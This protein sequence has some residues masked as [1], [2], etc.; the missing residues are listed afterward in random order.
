MIML[1]FGI[2]CLWSAPAFSWKRL[3]HALLSDSSVNKN[4]IWEKPCVKNSLQ[5]ATCISTFC[6]N[7]T[8]D[9]NSRLLSS[10]FTRE[11]HSYL[12][13]QGS[14]KS[15][16][17]ILGSIVVLGVRRGYWFFPLHSSSLPP[18]FLMFQ[19]PVFP[20]HYLWLPFFL[21]SSVQDTLAQTSH[22]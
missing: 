5:S 16:G 21:A 9:G 1:R 6:V 20:L 15:P 8:G 10:Y 4:N 17:K 11:F 7:C 22:P 13:Q 2:F 14:I 18:P 12:L 19:K 3:S